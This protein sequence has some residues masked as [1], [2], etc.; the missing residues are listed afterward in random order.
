[1]AAA[2]SNAYI[3]SSLEK[4]SDGNGAE[5]K[6]FLSKFSR[7]C[8]IGNKVDG[9][10]P[11]KGQLLMLFVEGRARAALEEYEQTQGG[12]Q[13]TYAAL[14]AK[15]L[16]H[17]DNAETRETS[18]SLF[19]VCCQ[20]VNESE[21]EFMLRLLMLYK[22]ANPDH[23]DAVTLLAVKRKFLSGIPPSLKKNMYVFCSDPLAA[24]VTREQ[25]LSHCRKA[26]NLMM[27]SAESDNT[28]STD[29][30]LVNAGGNN[31]VHHPTRDDDLVAAVNNL[32]LRFQEHVSNTEKR[33]D[34]MGGVIAVMGGAGGGQRQRGFGRG[35]GANNFRGR[36]N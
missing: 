29:K 31:N 27:N 3:F 25:L 6:S 5:L 20:K 18:M 7:C 15:L 36:G 30:V 19:D 12:N 28:Y 1:M 22:T 16:E 13:L 9:D 14:S 8:V 26:R 4:F 23:T 34:D 32:S 35:R 33:F 21:E 2:Q 17:F 11:V 10:T 24:N